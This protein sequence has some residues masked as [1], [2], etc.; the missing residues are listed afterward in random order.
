[1]STVRER[2]NIASGEGG[3]RG[4]VASRARGALCELN[5]NDPL[6]GILDAEYIEGGDDGK[7]WVVSAGLLAV[8]AHVVWLELDNCLR[9]DIAEEEG[10]PSIAL[11]VLRA[12]AGKV[13]VAERVVRPVVNVLCLDDD[14]HGGADTIKYQHGVSAHTRIAVLAD[15]EEQ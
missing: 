15:K 3:F 12:L 5:D 13:E 8:L 4:G 6:A 14:F 11:A 10:Y 2:L 1:M 7:A 9:H